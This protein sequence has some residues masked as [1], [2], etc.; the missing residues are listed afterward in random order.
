M[1]TYCKG[2]VLCRDRVAEAYDVWR[3]SKA[4]RKNA[5]RVA[6]EYGT[7]DALIDEIAT[8]AMGRSLWFRPI[9][10]YTRREPT[11]GKV[12][13]IGVESV[14][15]QVVDY[16]AVLAMQPLLDAKLGHWQVAGVSGR[17][18]MACRRAMRKWVREGGYHV[19]VDIRK[20]YPS[21]SHDVIRGLVRRYTKSEDLWYLVDAL[22]ATY[23]SGLEIGSFFSLHM[24]NLVMS[25][26]YHHL[27]GLHKERRGRKVALISHQL[28]HLD[29]GLIL[30]RDK[31][32]LKVAVRSLER[33]MRERFGI[34]FKG[35]KVARTTDVEP[36]DM[37]GF[38]VRESRITL[39]PSTWL[40]AS[41]AFIR[42]G[43]RRGVRLAQRVVSYWGWLR[44]TDSRRIVRS[45]GLYGLFVRARRVVSRAER[46]EECTLRAQR[47]LM[48]CS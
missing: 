43:R 39:R 9:R 7:A 15:Q 5:W 31:R 19:K 12:R 24:A 11:N 17:G 41:R 16:M 47:S 34:E 3:T 35:W 29:D 14:K 37:G 8:E 23:G 44:H 48:P 25:F 4:G 20:C 40:R 13:V 45:N 32:N 22:L 18:Q 21:I 27:E 2:Y 33:Y 1:K 6:R 10:R 38:V 46:A 36:L 42:F 26:A 30:S 28:W